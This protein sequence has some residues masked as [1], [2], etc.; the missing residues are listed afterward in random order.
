MILKPVTSEKAV[1]MIDVD[2]ILLFEVDRRYNKK[3]IAEE[4]EGAFEVKVSAVRTLIRKN[5]KFAYV[6]LR[7]DNP[8]ID[9]ATKLGMI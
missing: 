8:A 9:V 1:K 5:K 6:K 4:I 7:K 2:N 3:E